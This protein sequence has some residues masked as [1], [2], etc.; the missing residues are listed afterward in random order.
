M[1]KIER[2]T[3]AFETALASTRQIL[4]LAHIAH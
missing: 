1:V 3:Q 4:H 2:T